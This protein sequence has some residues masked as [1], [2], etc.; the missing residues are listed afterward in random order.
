LQSGRIICVKRGGALRFDFERSI[1]QTV[2]IAS[3]ED[4]ARAFSPRL[5]GSLQPNASTAADDHD[6]LTHELG[7]DAHAASCGELA[8]CSLDHVVQY[9][10]ANAHAICELRIDA[11]YD[12]SR[13]KRPERLTP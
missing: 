1:L 10:R 4:N 7:F 11:R 8:G 5:P 6:G 12:V 9:A 13:Q 3:R 2:G